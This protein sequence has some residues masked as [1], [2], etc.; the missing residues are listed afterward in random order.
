MSSVDVQDGSKSSSKWSAP[1]SGMSETG[2]TIATNTSRASSA[3]ISTN[4]AYLPGASAATG[5]TNPSRASRATGASNWTGASVAE[6]SLRSSSSRPVAKKRFVLI[7]LVIGFLLSRALLGSNLITLPILVLAG[8]TP[9]IVARRRE[10]KRRELLAK[11]WPE[12]LDHMISGLRSGMSIPETIVGLA[13]RGPEI[14]RPIFQRC[15]ELLKSGADIKLVFTQ[16]KS[17]FDDPIAD[18]VCEVLDFA[19]GTGS[20]DT[21]VTLRTLGD[22][23]RSDI[24]VRGEISAKLGW[25]KNSALVAAAAPWIL[26][27]ILSS[28]PS[29]MQA[30]STP[31]GTLILFAGVGLSAIA[32]LW[33]SKVGRV[34]SV[35]RIFHGSAR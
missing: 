15:Q 25:I 34:Q 21:A 26:L 16:I 19:R 22:F 23:V 27:L 33:M 30:F 3:T 9:Y 29:T 11:L 28:Q 2:A 6:N 5:A 7:S 4:P 32:Y 8:S 12:L 24:A 20:R 17:E 13:V 18:Q 31:A 35:P 14:S 10:V 1:R